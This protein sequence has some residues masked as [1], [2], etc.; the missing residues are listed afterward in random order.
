MIG[1][2]INIYDI[3]YFVLRNGPKGE[4]NVM[5]PVFKCE[6]C[7]KM[8]T[9]EEIREHESSCSE[10]YNK[11]S[12]PTCKHGKI[13]IKNGDVWFE[14]SLGKEIPQGCMIE[15]CPSYERLIRAPSS[16]FIS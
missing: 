8:G 12:C 6:Y 14:C 10:N 11:K 7:S 5:K 9:E 16:G 13:K 1:L 3:V 15:F 4:E 2:M